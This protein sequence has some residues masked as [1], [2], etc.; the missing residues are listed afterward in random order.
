MNTVLGGR[1][2]GWR[3]A[4][5]CA[6][7]LVGKRD[8]G[9]YARAE[10]DLRRVEEILDAAIA[11]GLARAAEAGAL[12]REREAVRLA[13]EADTAA[14]R[15]VV[16][17]ADAQGSDLALTQRAHAALERAYAAALAACAPFLAAEDHPALDHVIAAYSARAARREDAEDAEDAGGPGDARDGTA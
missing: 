12:V 3:R 17:L 4:G 5:Q 13:R 9:A 6:A 7:A 10:E 1:P 15:L 14:L 16:A 2:G 8:A 11:R